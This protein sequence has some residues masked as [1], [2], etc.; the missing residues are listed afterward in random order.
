ML[1]FGRITHVHLKT[2][3]TLAF[4]K[5]DPMLYLIPN[6]N[7]CIKTKDIHCVCPGNPFIQDI[8]NY[9]CSLRAKSPEQKCQGKSSVKDE[10]ME[11]K[12]ERAG[13]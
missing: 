13:N 11:T 6:L 10:G 4:H 12:V 2:P 3:P 1:G 9:L 8:N 5:E 7:L